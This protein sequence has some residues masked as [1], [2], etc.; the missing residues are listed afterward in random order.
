MRRLVQEGQDAQERDREN[1]FEILMCMAIEQ[2]VKS[3]HNAYNDDE[4]QYINILL[5]TV[6]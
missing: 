5:F 2:A 1:N 4:E 3:T 6:I